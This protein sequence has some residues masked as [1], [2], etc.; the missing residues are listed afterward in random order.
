MQPQIIEN[1][2]DSTLLFVTE[3][4]PLPRIWKSLA[5]KASQIQINGRQASDIPCSDI[6]PYGY[7]GKVCSQRLPRVLNLFTS[8]EMITG[9]TDI[10]QSKDGRLNS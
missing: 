8:K 9:H 3:S 5:R 2:E 10:A 7:A 4:L 6:I 1:E